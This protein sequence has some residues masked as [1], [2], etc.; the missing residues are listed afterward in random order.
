MNRDVLNWTRQTYS[1]L[2]WLGDIGGLLDVLLHLGRIVVFPIS[3]FTLKQ[4]LMSS[5]FR[6]KSSNSANNRSETAQTVKKELRASIKIPSFSWYY[7][8]CLCCHRS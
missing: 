1:L 4:L 8:N 5:L 7:I 2:D 6:Y 3:S